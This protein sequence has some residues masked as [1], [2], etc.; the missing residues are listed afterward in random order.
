MSWENEVYAVY[1]KALEL[2]EERV[3]LL[4][5]SHSTAKAQ[6]EVTIDL[7]GNFKT[8]DVITD[9]KDAMTIIPVTED[10]GARSSGI[11]PHPFA[12]K[13]VY[14]AGDYC[15][16]CK[17]KK[18]EENKFKAYIE[19]LGKWKNSEY[20]H[21]SV[22]ALYSYLSKGELISDLVS[23]RVLNA[24]NGELTDEKVMK[25]AQS[26][27]FVRFRVIGAGEERTWRDKSLFDKFIEYNAAFQVE[28]SMCYATAKQ[29]ACTYKHPSKVLNAGDKGK[30]FSANDD[31]GFSYRGRFL[32]KEQ[33]VSIGYEFSQKMHNALKWL[34]ERQGVP[35]G[36]TM[37][38]VWSGTLNKLP[39]IVKNSQDIIDD[40]DMDF[41]PAKDDFANY[42]GNIKKAIFGSKHD[43]DFND[44]V[45]ILALDEATTGRVSVNMYS[46]L[47]ES[48][49]YRNVTNWHTDTAWNRFNFLKKENYIGS[50]ALTQ[51]AEFAY[52]TEQNGQME[53]KPEIKSDV[54]M[55]L[56]PCV[57]EG[58][59]LPKDIVTQ[60]VNRV[61][62]RTA[63]DKTWNTLLGITCAMIRKSIIEKGGTVDMA[64]DEN[65]KDRSY[66]FG[67]LLA[68]AEKAELDTYSEDDKKGRVPNARRF[69]ERFS[70][71]PYSTWQVIRE[72]LIPYLNKLGNNN[73]YD[74][75]MT[76][77]CDKFTNFQDPDNTSETQFDSDEKLSPLYL[78]GY[79]HQ[80]SAFYSPKN[81]NDKD[82]NNEEEKL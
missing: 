68:V 52:G 65:C 1:D 72:R 77:I 13:L 38:V 2:P 78:L 82:N 10:S 12:D 44:K 54:L 47:P 20:S 50:F 53:C 51:I 48:E 81:S 46:E 37:L 45:M 27:C 3:R 18:E 59:K 23:A 41:E 49:F 79:S 76:E 22:N 75:L 73:R 28:K 24:Q 5:I 67:R 57:T 69:W 29:T 7:Q 25:I 17:S 63:Y 66:L 39:N 36:S 35:L 19:Q 80:R 16:F 6:I 9:E 30:L 60:L 43:L 14:I 40:L 32:S 8:A 55:R 42:K 31:A 11:C 62:R 15:D 33:A 70:H 61:S 74:K 58:R 34:I 4:P 26:D 56:I 71:S 21:A 64:L